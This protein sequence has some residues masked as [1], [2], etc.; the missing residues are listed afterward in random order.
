MSA[1][2]DLILA[3]G[4]VWTPD[5]VKALVVVPT[6]AADTLIGYATDDVLA[7]LGGN[8]NLYGRAGHDTLDGGAGA[9][10]LYGED[11]NDLLD[12]GADGDRLYGGNGDDTLN[13]G[14]GIDY[15]YGEAGHDLLDGGAGNDSLYGGAGNDIFRF[16]RG[17]GQDTI[18]AYDTTAGKVDRLEAGAGKLDLVFSK[19]GSNLVVKIHGDAASATV[20]SWNSGSAY[21]TQ[22]IGS[23]DGFQLLNSQVDQLIQAMASF[24]ADRGGITWDQAIDQYAGDVQTIISAY[25]QPAAA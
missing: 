2:Y 21:Q 11:G 23:A 22:Q 1:T 4:T 15:L 8:D 20:S 14:D 10:W 24:C 12:G 13:G 5:V 6:E 3:N 17:G 18:N 7:G 25:W 9:D 19:S 16:G